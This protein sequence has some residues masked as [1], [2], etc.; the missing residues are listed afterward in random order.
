[1]VD[2]GRTGHVCRPRPRFPCINV[3]LHWRAA[4][5][6]LH[7]RLMILP[8]GL[9]RSRML[10]F[11]CLVQPDGQVANGQTH[12]GNIYFP[13]SRISEDAGNRQYQESLL[14]SVL[15]NKKIPSLLAVTKT[16]GGR[17]PF[18]ALS[19]TDHHGNH[20]ERDTILIHSVPDTRMHHCNLSSNE[21]NLER[22][23]NEHFAGHHSTVYSES[24]GLFLCETMF[25]NGNYKE[26]F[27]GGEEMMIIAFYWRNE[28]WDFQIKYSTDIILVAFFAVCVACSLANFKNTTVIKAR[29]KLHGTGGEHERV[30]T[31]SRQGVK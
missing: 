2:G 15:V 24:N 29:E 21:P 28:D 10:G 1:M 17:G 27:V 3:A 26:E 18:Q 13:F 31:R 16:L 12:S 11:Y 9:S 4:V 25:T 19:Y 14:S 5:Q 22:R 20:R 6:R 8:S 30:T 23:S 7:P